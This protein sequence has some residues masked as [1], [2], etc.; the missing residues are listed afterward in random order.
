MKKIF[1][2]KKY[3]F[4]IGKE[5]GN[6]FKDLK[7]ETEITNSLVTV[8][9]EKTF[10][11]Q[12]HE[13]KFKLITSIIGKGAFCVF[14]GEING[15]KG[16]IEVQI[17]KAFRILILIWLILP[18]IA[19][20]SSIIEVGFTNSIGVIGVFVITLFLLRFVVIELFFNSVAKNGIDKLK[21]ILG[22]IEIKE[23]DNL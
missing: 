15:N 14:E 6:A 23:N 19:V 20:S 12:V 21:T 11:G 13:T 4:Q 5:P 22:I 1:P 16:V 7:N 17:D 9:T 10:I 8:L 3:E 18:I 2:R